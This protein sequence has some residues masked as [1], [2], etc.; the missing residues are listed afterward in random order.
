MNT[1]I[2]LIED[3]KAI[4]RLMKGNL[5]FEGFDVEWCETGRQA[6]EK[7][8]QFVPHLV[9]LDLMLP[10]GVDGLQICRSLTESP[11]RTPVIILTAKDQQADKVRGLVAGADDYV[12]K[13]FAFD[14]LLARIR[15]VLRRTTARLDELHLGETVIDFRRL[16]ASTGNRALI[17]T[18]KEFEILRYLG[19]R[20]GKIVSRDELLHLVWGYESTPVTR[21]VDNFIFRLRQ[22]IE[23][24]PRHPQFIHTVYGGGYRLTIPT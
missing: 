8:K 13:P 19:E 18:D 23:P 1:R 24:D 9:L 12:T 11:E 4:G 17:L 6:E 21:T 3:D 15:A 7:V 22:K 5:Q 14:E 2:L 20:E 16:R 10:A